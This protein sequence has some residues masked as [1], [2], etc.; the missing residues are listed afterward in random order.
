MYV[1]MYM[2]EV[3]S[4]AELRANLKRHLDNVTST[5]ERVVVARQGKPSAVLISQ[6]DL[7]SLEETVSVLSDPAAMA[8]LSGAQ[9]EVDR[10][11]VYSAD[12]VREEMRAEGRL[13]R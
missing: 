6:D 8:D 13:A 7:E 11:E 1:L 9:D 4:A 12:A 2:T 5:H 3:V 10:G